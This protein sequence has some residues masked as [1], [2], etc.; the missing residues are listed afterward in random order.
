MTLKN[1]KVLY[2][3]RLE[4]NKPVDDILNIYPELADKSEEKEPKEEKPEVKPNGHNSIRRKK[5]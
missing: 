2:A 1:A 3:H 4:L 5:G